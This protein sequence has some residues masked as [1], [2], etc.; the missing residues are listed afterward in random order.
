MAE[1]GVVTLQSMATT[2]TTATTATVSP[3][4][5]LNCTVWPYRYNIQLYR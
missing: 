2:A 3:R 4:E 1:A 5:V